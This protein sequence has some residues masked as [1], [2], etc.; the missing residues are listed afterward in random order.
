MFVNRT[1]SGGR[2]AT[3][4]ENGRS[5][6]TTNRETTSCSAASFALSRSWFASRSSSAS[7][8]PRATEPAIGWACARAPIRLTSSSGDA[9]A[10]AVPS[11]P[12]TR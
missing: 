1:T 6:S 8:A 5:A 12:V 9:P 10:K 2:A 11:A 3:L 7:V 4:R